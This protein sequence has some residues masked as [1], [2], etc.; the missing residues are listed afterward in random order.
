MHQGAPHHYIFVSSNIA[1]GLFNR[2]SLCARHL[3]P[4]WIALTLN[5]PA[6]PHNEKNG[7][8]N[9]I[10]HGHFSVGDTAFALRFERAVYP[11]YLRLVI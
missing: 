10:T 3:K 1:G 5:Q 7:V 4:V 9:G 11:G 2:R 6:P 8:E